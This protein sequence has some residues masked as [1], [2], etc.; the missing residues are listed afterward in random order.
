M[1]MVN[2]A[3]LYILYSDDSFR[4]DFIVQAFI[5]PVLLDFKCLAMLGSFNVS[6]ASP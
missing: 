4:E 1:Y 6:V 2:V 5:L 3:R